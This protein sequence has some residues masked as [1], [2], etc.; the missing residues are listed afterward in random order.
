MA[1]EKLNKVKWRICDTKSSENA[2][3]QETKL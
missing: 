1:T 2:I 3:L